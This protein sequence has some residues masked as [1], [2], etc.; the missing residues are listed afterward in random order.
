MNTENIPS[1]EE[2]LD[3]MGVEFTSEMEIYRENNFQEVYNS[4]VKFYNC[5]K[6]INDTIEAGFPMI[7]MLQAFYDGGF[8]TG[9]NYGMYAQENFEV[10]DMDMITRHQD[11]IANEF[12][13]K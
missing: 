6:E 10:S 7:Q 3:K 2:Q 5:G 4:I 9:M 13:D 11:E 1:L 8:Y 12:K